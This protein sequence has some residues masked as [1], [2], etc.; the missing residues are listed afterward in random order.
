MIPL[1]RLLILWTI[2]ALLLTG[3]ELPQAER[4][5]SGAGLSVHYIDVG[6]ADSILLQC[7][8]EAMLIDGGNVEDSQTVVS[9]LQHQG[10]EELSYVVNTHAHEDHVGGLAGVLAVFEADAVWCPVAEYESQCF[11][12][13]VTYTQAQGLSLTCP[14]PGSVFPLGEAQ[15]TVLGPL[16]SY[17]D[18]N[19]TSIVLRVDYGE[20]SFLFTGDMERTAEED[21]LEAGMDVSA[22]VLKAGHHGSDTSSSYPFLRAVDPEAVVISVGEGN[23][24]GHPDEAALSRFRDAGATVYRTDLQ[25]DLVFST[26]G[27]E[28]TVSTAREAAVTNPTEY[29][30]SGQFSADVTY[31]GNTKSHKF[32]LPTC[33]SLPEPQNQT[34]FSSYDD[35]IEAGYSPCSR[36]LG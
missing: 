19:N 33:S 1:K 32:H 10:V 2:L 17:D 15:V 24:Y 16:E 36:C 6:Q 20:T 3:C 29:D 12:D 27:A 5:V 30:G 31:I 18:P 26:D 11:D 25:G 7:D 34:S 9:Y 14:E 28:I 22:D 13:F 4:T 35:A 21:L 8:G 23:S